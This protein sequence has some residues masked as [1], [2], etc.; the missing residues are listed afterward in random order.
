MI[1]EW[2][3]ELHNNKIAAEIEIPQVT[4]HYNTV[5]VLLE[6]MVILKTDSNSW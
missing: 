4:S 1:M 6:V 2:W 5:F 3:L